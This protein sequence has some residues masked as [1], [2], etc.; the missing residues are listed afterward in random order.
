MKITCV[1]VSEPNDK[2]VDETTPELFT[3][4]EELGI[5]LND[6]LPTKF[7]VLDEELRKNYN[8][9]KKKKSKKKH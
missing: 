8:N 4:R 1:V 3:G 2:V 9:S 7:P 5:W 6:E